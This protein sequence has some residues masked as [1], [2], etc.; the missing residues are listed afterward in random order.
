[1]TTSL[2]LRLAEDDTE[3]PVHLDGWQRQQRD[4]RDDAY[5][6]Q[7]PRGVVPL[8][9]S[10]DNRKF[11]STIEEQGSL[12]SCT[13]Q[14][15]AGMLE[16]NEVRAG[17]K[18]NA[19]TEPTGEL[20]SSSSPQIQVSNVT[21]S[22]TGAISFTTTVLPGTQAPTPAPSP[23]P[24][25]APSNK[26]VHVSR[27]FGYYATRLLQGTTDFDSGAT[28]RNTIKAA[29]NY[30]VVNEALYPY[31]PSQFAANPPQSIWDTAAKYRVTSYHALADGDL[32]SMKSALAS[33]YLIGFGFDVY[34]AFLSSAVAKS[35]LLC[36]PTKTETLQGG[37]AV[38]LAGYDDSKVMPDGS[39]GAF[40]VRNSWGAKWGQAGYF[41]MAY[42][43]VAD[44]NLCSDFWIV[45]S[46]P[47]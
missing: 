8:P 26:F 42:N 2:K 39:R 4:Q 19:E 41:W 22:P 46:S 21:V 47:I 16:A 44:T 23:S 25:P 7:V 35:G 14:M 27:L 5:R 1:M 9:K 20:L 32:N 15:L 13:A 3:L 34:S 11:C 30:G 28:I 18:L 38:C 36:R 10:V 29:A 33:G 17:R 24:L 6:L 12:G 43:Y 45:Q 40:L 31:V 37:H